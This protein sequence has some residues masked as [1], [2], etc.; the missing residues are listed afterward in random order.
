MFLQK[1]RLFG[2]S[3]F[4][5]PRFRTLQF[6]L[7][8]G[9]PLIVILLVGSIARP[10]VVSTQN[11]NPG[12]V[13]QAS[14]DLIRC[15]VSAYVMR[16]ND[17]DFLEGSFF[18]D[19]WLGANCNR[20]DTLKISNFDLPTAKKSNFLNTTAVN[21]DTGSHFV[22]NLEGTFSQDW[23]LKN[24]PFDR[25]Q[26]KISLE[27]GGTEDLSKFVFEPDSKRSALHPDLDVEDGWKITNFS[28]SS[29]I[30][31]YMTNFGDPKVTS[32]RLPYSQLIIT[33][34]IKRTSYIGF[35]KL[36]SGVYIAFAICVLCVFL[37][38]SQNNMFTTSLN[39]LV[40]C[41]FAV[42]VNFQ[43]ESS[44]LGTVEGLTMTDRIH[45]FTMIYILLICIIQTTFHWLYR[46]EKNK[47]IQQIQ[48][49]GWGAL[50]GSYLLIN[51]VL[52]VSARLAG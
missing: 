31:T 3:L 50:I 16:L 34:E 40:G 15:Q 38:V 35:F 7:C 49:L 45:I 23:D 42:F 22:T 26:L 30:N 36:V 17:F 5:K 11:P 14:N 2:K 33:F 9:F 21:N 52:I 4:R 41:L 51:T 47:T 18:I 1:M 24:Y 20:P 12:V 37:D 19:V 6:L 13:P 46:D 39:I 10:T 29:N 25:H 48:A 27:L 44:M 43:V 28:V 8:C 32:D